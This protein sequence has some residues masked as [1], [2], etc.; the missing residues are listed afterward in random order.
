MT[1]LLEVLESM[2]V[3]WALLVVAITPVITLTMAFFLK[4]HVQHWNHED[5]GFHTIGTKWKRIFY[6]SF[7]GSW[8]LSLLAGLLSNFNLYAIAL[9]GV[10]SYVLIFSSITDII[11]HKAPKEVARY[12][13]IASG[14]LMATAIFDYFIN[15]SGG[16]VN[17]D[18]LM[19][20]PL[21]STI[22]EAQLWAAG[23][24][25]IIP[26]VLLIVSRGGMGM[27][28]IRLL[29]LFGL[30]MSWW[31]GVMGMFIAFFVANVLQIIAFLPAT[32]FNWGHMITMKNGKEKRAVPF[33][34]ALTIG[35]ITMSLVTLSQISI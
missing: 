29:I 1:K 4:R 19:Q 24:W 22:W 33:I 14:I 7:I 35:F 5:R 18:A 17:M 26:I 9:M 20:L 23:I 16:L 34:P 31:V 15:R 28:D 11:V 3:V 25:F 21:G 6:Y 30:N 12:G 13:I 10:L 27:A 32:K 2:P 8:L